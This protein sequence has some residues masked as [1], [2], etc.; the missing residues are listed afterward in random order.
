MGACAAEDAAADDAASAE[1]AAAAV[2]APVRAEEEAA[3]PEALQAVSTRAAVRAAEGW[4]RI[5]N[6]PGVVIST[7]GPGV[8][9]AITGIAQAWTDS[10]PLIYIYGNSKKS[11]LEIEKKTGMR[12]YGAQDVPSIELLKPITK[13]C[14]FVNQ[15][16]EVV[17]ILEEAFTIA[18]SGR[19]GP[20]SIEIPLDVQNARLS[21]GYETLI[22][23]TGKDNCSTNLIREM[24]VS[25]FVDRVVANIKKANRPIIIAGQGVRL[26]NTSNELKDLVHMTRIPVVTSRMGNDVIETSDSLFIGRPGQYGNRASHFAIQASDLIVVLGSRLSLNTT[27]YAPE[28]FAQNANI[29][30]V[31]VDTNEISKEGIDTLFSG[32]YDLKDVMPIFVKKV[33]K[34]G[35]CF[36]KWADICLKW[37]EKYPIIQKEYSNMNPISTYKAIEKLSNLAKEGD[38]I[39]SDTGTCCNIVS[40]VWEVKKDQRLLI[41]GGLSCMG[42]WV[43]A[44]GCALANSY[45]NTICIVGDGSFQMNIQE[46]AVISNN[47][48]NV[49]LFVVNNNGYQI[50]KIGQNNYGMSKNIAVDP[51]SGL[52]FADTE[53]VA[54]AYNIPYRRVVNLNEIE[55]VFSETLS[56]NGPFLCEIVVNENQLTIP[57]LKSKAK[58]DGTF[59]SPEFVDLYPFLENE[60]IESELKA[61]YI[62]TER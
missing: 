19:P 34:E 44:I 11:V 8:T 33:E 5:S 36:N 32:N 3:V 17:T 6:L 55:N 4:G 14:F 49:K 38:I 48:I 53:K 60:E 22:P 40:Q 15:A 54:V 59:V 12:Q 26:S 7:N 25:D 52:S 2:T 18:T 41:S 56:A 30:P 29:I 23:K 45:S 16:D 9:N 10:A 43:T 42:F 50:I 51:Q 27:G 37:K 39:L 28:K 1:D 61:A 58:E 31:D 57:K 35:I 62:K 13:K 46:L 20:V 21:D 24:D 47:N